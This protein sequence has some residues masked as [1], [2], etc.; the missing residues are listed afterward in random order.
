MVNIKK[1]K[2]ERIRSVTKIKEIFLKPLKND[3]R[4][5]ITHVFSKNINMS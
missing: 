3:L 5:F 2:N 1:K 4:K